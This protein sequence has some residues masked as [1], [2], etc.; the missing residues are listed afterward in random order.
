MHTIYRRRLLVFVPAAISLGIAV[1]LFWASFALFISDMHMG[2]AIA[3]LVIAVL[4]GIPSII[5]AWRLLRFKVVIGHA[6]LTAPKIRPLNVKIKATDTE[7]LK[8]SDLQTQSKSALELIGTVFDN[9]MFGGRYRK[10]EE[11]IQFSQVDFFDVA[12]IKSRHKR[13]IFI[14]FTYNDGTKRV[15]E[16]RPLGDIKAARLVDEI[17][18]Y[19]KM[20]DTFESTEESGDG[21]HLADSLGIGLGDLIVAIIGCC[22]EGL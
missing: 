9:K 15:I 18:Q 12:K 20:R 17:T 14:L 11:E 10:E 2:W 7:E 8:V 1:C 13:Y 16:V 21:Y 22:C 3:M 4:V 6:G 5:L 19:V